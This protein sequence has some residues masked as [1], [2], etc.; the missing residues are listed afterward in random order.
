MKMTER[1]ILQSFAINNEGE[2]VSVR[3]VVRGKACEC[4]CPA[5]GEV[6]IA[7]Q[8]EIRAWHFAHESGNDCEGGAESALHLA[9]KQV[10]ASASQI[11]T[12]PLDVTGRHEVDGQVASAITS[13]PS[14]RLTIDRAQLEIPWRT[15]LG[16]IKPDVVAVSSR[17]KLFIEVAVTHTVDAEKKKKIEALNISTMEIHIDPE[18]MEEWTWGELRKE[19]LENPANRLWVYHCDEH[20]LLLEANTLALQKI[21]ERTRDSTNSYDEIRLTLHS[22]P[23]HIREYNWGVTLWSGFDRSTNEILKSIARRFGGRWNPKYKNWAYGPGLLSPL[24]EYL[25]ELGATSVV[26]TGLDGSQPRASIRLVK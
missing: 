14:E 19:V 17:G 15:P 4:A 6:L 1:K 21:L 3:D 20:R 5:C 22:I 8:G 7:R 26:S 11:L 10:V 12:P 16:E 24:N 23:V 18:F 2:V 25:N 9:A 13:I